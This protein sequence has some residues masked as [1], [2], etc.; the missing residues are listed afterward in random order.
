M[1]NTI[2]VNKEAI[3]D[4]VR[5]KEEFNSIVE[6]LELMDNKEFIRSYKK[7]KDQIK[8]REFDDWN[9]L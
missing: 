2:T 4:L 8:R 6:S 5:I 7:A 9:A 1:A 3:T